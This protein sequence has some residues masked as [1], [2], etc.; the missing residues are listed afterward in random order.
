MFACGD[1]M[2]SALLLPFCP[3]PLAPEPPALPLPC[4]HATTMIHNHSTETS[5]YQQ[6]TA[7]QSSTGQDRWLLVDSRVINYFSFHR[8]VVHVI[9]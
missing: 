8:N 9:L 2:S 4:F 7:L 1:N 5:I 3:T 6:P